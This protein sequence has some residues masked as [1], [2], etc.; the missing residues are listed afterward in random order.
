VL[1]I[2]GCIFVHGTGFIGG[3]K[4]REGPL[5]MAVKCLRNRD[6]VL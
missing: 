6:G 2:G 5:E 3:S 4:T 1:G